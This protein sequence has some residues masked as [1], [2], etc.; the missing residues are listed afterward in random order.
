MGA[1]GCANE[2]PLEAPGSRGAESATS[3]RGRDISHFS[4]EFCI[5]KK[6]R[7]VDDLGGR[8]ELSHGSL[9]C[10]AAASDSLASAAE[11]QHPPPDST[12]WSAPTQFHSS[13][14]SFSARPSNL[15]VSPSC[16]EAIEDGSW[17]QSAWYAHL[18]SITHGPARRPLRIIGVSLF[19]GIGAF[20]ELFAPFMGSSMEWAAQFSCEIA[21]DCLRV[22]EHRFPPFTAYGVC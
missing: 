22:L 9:D 10:E 13:R 6:R 11:F 4:S 16:V 5:P 14:L 21:A 20:W 17:L 7:I 2:V 18:C 15:N 1:D 19:D 8:V 12:P 3:P